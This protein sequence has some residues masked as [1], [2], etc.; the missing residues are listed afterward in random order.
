MQFELQ[1]NWLAEVRC[2]CPINDVN[3]VT[4]YHD[5]NFMSLLQSAKFFPG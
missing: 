2:I 5:W 4:D 3:K 1:P